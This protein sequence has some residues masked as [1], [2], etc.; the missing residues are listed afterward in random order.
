MLA[1]MYLASGL[2]ARPPTHTTRYFSAPL[3]MMLLTAVWTRVVG[4]YGPSFLRLL[5]TSAL[6]AAVWR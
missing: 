3:Y 1:Y 6:S 5:P 2:A 4:L